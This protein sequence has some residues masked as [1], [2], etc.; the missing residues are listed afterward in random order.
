MSM[1]HESQSQPPFMCFVVGLV[2]IA[3][4]PG[5]GWLWGQFVETIVLCIG[6]AFLIYA[7]IAYMTEVN[8]RLTALERRLAE[9]DR[10]RS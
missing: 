1:P 9:K 10:G 3:A 5:I 2:F 8:N 7:T 6:G 4:V